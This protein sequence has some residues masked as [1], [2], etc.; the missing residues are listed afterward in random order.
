MIRVVKF[1]DCDFHI[2]ALKAMLFSALLSLLHT[3]YLWIVTSQNIIYSLTGR[4]PLL[5]IINIFINLIGIIFASLDAYGSFVTSIGALPGWQFCG[6]NLLLNYLIDD[7]LILMLI[8]IPTF[9]LIRSSLRNQKNKRTA[10]YFSAF[11]FHYLIL[12]ITFFMPV[13]FTAFNFPQLNEISP[14]HSCGTPLEGG[15]RVR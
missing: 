1:F 6:T 14:N 8:Y 12:I 2:C 3:F 9:I 10:L 7:F 4:S 5:D 15:H 13:C 11:F